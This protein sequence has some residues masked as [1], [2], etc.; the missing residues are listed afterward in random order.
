M[1]Q[2]HQDVVA[3]VGHDAMKRANSTLE[4]FQHHAIPVR[5]FAKAAAPPTFK[6]DALNNETT[7]Y[8][9]EARQNSHRGCQP[10]KKVVSHKSFSQISCTAQN[11]LLHSLPLFKLAV[12]QEKVWFS[13]LWATR[14]ELLLLDI[15]NSNS[16][17]PL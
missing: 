15:N 4:D 12:M 9:D 1:S 5:A 14:H 7:C 2:K 16:Q 13:K 17:V 6:G 3:M 11:T 8:Y 10:C